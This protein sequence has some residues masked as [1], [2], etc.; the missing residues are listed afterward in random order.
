MTKPDLPTAFYAAAG[1]G[2]LAYQ[3]LRKLPEA[4]ERAL[5]TAGETATTLRE[6]VAA[7]EARLPRER[8]VAEVA[9]LRES[10]QR[11]ALTVV[12]SAATAQNKAVTGYQ[13][14]VAHGEKVVAARNG[15]TIK[16]APAEID[17]PV[18]TDASPAAAATASS[19]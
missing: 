5:R 15:D 7:G 6:R 13:N 2:D 11:G 16:V 3:Q 19:S 4:T 14:L 1:A 12:S 17:S 8:I 18:A 9:R 10:A